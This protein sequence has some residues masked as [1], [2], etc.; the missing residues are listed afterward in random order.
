MTRTRALL[1]TFVLGSVLT[2]AAGGQGSGGPDTV[3]VQSGPLRLRALLWRPRGRGPFPAI[4]FNHGSG[5]N[6]TQ[7]QQLGPYEHQADALGPVFARHGYVFLYLFRQGVGLSADQGANSI[8]L[9][10]SAFAAGGQ[11]SRNALQLRLLETREMSDALAGLGFLRALP[12]VNPRAI[13]VVGHSFGASLTLL[14]AERDST[15][16][17]AVAFSGSAA[18]WAHSPELR[19]R[20]LAAV[21]HSAVPILF[22]QAANDYSIAP[23]RALDAEM[24]RLEKPHRL[25]IYPPVG[26]TADE[27]HGFIYSAVSMWEPDVFA[28]LDEHLWR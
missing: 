23:G 4:L 25:K 15:L 17:A 11:A 19:K 24:T 13:A 12:A 7:L 18:S 21:G 26:Q 10:D 16:R 8:D 22:L 20:L 5:R 27:G 6:R 2:A 3:V 28:F 1:L 9:M 14:V